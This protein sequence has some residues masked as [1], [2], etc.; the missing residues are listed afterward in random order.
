VLLIA[1]SALATCQVYGQRG[2]G[3]LVPWSHHGSA[4]DAN[5]VRHDGKDY[6][7]GT[8]LPWLDDVIEAYSPHY[9]YGDRLQRNEGR[10]VYRLTLDLN[11][12]SVTQL[13]TLK[14]TGIG[15]LDGCA[16][17]AF[18]RWRWKPRK[19]KEIDMA[20]TFQ[21][22]RHA[23]NPPGVIKLPKRS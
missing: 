16:L 17:S 5:G 12:G 20:V 1:L 11:T 3:L 10:G 15:T 23:P 7:S 4:V 9:P 21:L 18:R 13:V 22:R 19:W 2:A 6:P 8:H 14:S